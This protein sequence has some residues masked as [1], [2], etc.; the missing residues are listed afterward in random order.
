MV[1]SLNYSISVFQSLVIKIKPVI[2]EA[3][4]FI[5]IPKKQTSK[6]YGGKDYQTWMFS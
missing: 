1:L 4:N 6:I 2:T 3:K 5:V